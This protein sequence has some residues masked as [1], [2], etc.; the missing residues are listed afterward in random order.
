MLLGKG[1]YSPCGKKVKAENTDTLCYSVR[2]AKD[3]WIAENTAETWGDA[4]I[5][6]PVSVEAMHTWLKGQPEAFIA[7]L[8]E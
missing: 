8:A 1:F 2:G 5:T 6:K 4:I 3:A 7:A